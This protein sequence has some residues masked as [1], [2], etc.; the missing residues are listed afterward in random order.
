MQRFWNETMRT[1]LL[2]RLGQELGTN[3]PIAQTIAFSIDTI[4]NTINKL[5][6][7]GF[8]IH[9]SGQLIGNNFGFAVLFG[10][11]KTF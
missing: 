3:S 1:L 5:F 6:L 2:I 9:F 10:F 4:I 11:T 7:I 8:F